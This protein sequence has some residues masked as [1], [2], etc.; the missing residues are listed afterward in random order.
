MKEVLLTTKRYRCATV[1]VDHYS[2]LSYIHIQKLTGAET[3][4]GKRQFEAYYASHSV[5]VQHYHADNG[6]FAVTFSRNQLTMV[7]RPSPIAA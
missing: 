6:Q 5:K 2:G 3:V 4:H 1:F 7:D